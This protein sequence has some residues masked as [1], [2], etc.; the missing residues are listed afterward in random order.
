MLSASLTLVTVVDV[1]STLY[2][3]C[4][5]GRRLLGSSE[6]HQVYDPASTHNYDKRRADFPF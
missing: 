1:K 5:V 6:L 2:R 3:P 4:Q